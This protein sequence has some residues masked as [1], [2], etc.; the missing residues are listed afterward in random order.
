[1]SCPACYCNCAPE[2][3]P[4]TVNNNA[5]TVVID[6]D[7]VTWYDEHFVTADSTGGLGV[8]FFTANEIAVPKQVIL[9]INNLPV[10][11]DAYTVAADRLSVSL[12]LGTLAAGDDLRIRYLGK[13]V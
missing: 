8:Q 10:P 4:V 2:T 6:G 5:Y 1:M 9:F 7:T 3:V 13:A 12:S 11:S